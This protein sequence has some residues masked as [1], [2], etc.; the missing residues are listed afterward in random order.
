LLA[1]PEQLKKTLL[2]HVISGTIYS[3]GLPP[4]AA[5]KAAGGD[6]VQVN[7]STR[8]LFSVGISKN[9]F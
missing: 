2:D 9:K 6:S 8:K 4:S 7:V 5:V 1:N 3:R